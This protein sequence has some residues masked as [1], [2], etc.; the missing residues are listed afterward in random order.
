M[1]A[2]SLNELIKLFVDG[3][4]VRG[5]VCHPQHSDFG[6]LLVLGFGNSP[7]VFKKLPKMHF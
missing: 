3:C 6:S 2:R 7:V 5:L 1:V 4:F